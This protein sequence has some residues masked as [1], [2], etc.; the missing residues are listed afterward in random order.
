MR[1]NKLYFCLL[2]ILLQL[3]F[4]IS[5]SAKTIETSFSHKTTLFKPGPR[6]WEHKIDIPQDLLKKG[7]VFTTRTLKLNKKLVIISEE[8]KPTYYYIKVG[9]PQKKP[10][11][12]TIKIILTTGKNNA[13]SAINAPDK[14]QLSDRLPLTLSWIG[15]GQYHSLVI[16]NSTTGKEVWERTILSSGKAILES[17]T[18]QERAKIRKQINEALARKDTKKALELT[19]KLSELKETPQD[20]PTGFAKF[21]FE[22]KNKAIKAQQNYIWA[23]RSSDKSGKYSKEARGSFATKATEE[24]CLFCKGKGE[25]TCLE[26]KGKGEVAKL[27]EGQEHL[28]EEE[29][30][31]NETSHYHFEPCAKC[32][33]TG[34]DKCCMCEG[35]GITKFIKVISK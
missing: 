3:V 9:I 31:D 21:Q 5:A 32:K 23:I 34:I 12:G 14:V 19:N 27:D 16:L 28:T 29:L 15:K 13:A 17:S 25:Y 10:G 7:E 8:L 33:G 18:N 4:T 1:S 6:T 30:E 26:C 22:I 24:D 35:S 11:K 20:K 2:I